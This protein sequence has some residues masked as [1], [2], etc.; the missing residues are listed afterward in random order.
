V[1]NLRKTCSQAT[2][3]LHSYQILWVEHRQSKIQCAAG[4]PN[5]WPRRW[6]ALM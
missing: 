6:N 2:I 1:E 3:D 4:L 5:C